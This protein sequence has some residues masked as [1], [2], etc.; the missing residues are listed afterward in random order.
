MNTYDFD[1][2]INRH[3][4]NSLKWDMYSDDVLPLW[5]ADM[6]FP[7]PPAV[8]AAMQTRLSHPVFGYANH[9]TEVLD[10]ICSWLQ[11][12]HGWQIAAEQILLMPGVVTGVNW[13]AK[14]FG[15]ANRAMLIQTPVYPPFFQA[16]KNAGL[17]LVEAPLVQTNSHY[18]I[19][20]ELFEQRILASNANIFILCNPHNPV[21]RVFTRGE[22]ERLGEI[23]LR[24]QV[25]ICSDEIHCDLTYSGY[26]HLPIASLSNELA[27]NTITLMAASKT[28]NIPGLH[29]SFAV[30]SNAELR[31]KMEN[32]RAGIIGHPETFANAAA[33][34]AFS[35]CDDWLEHLL[36][37]LEGNRDH[38]LSFLK[39]NMPAIQCPS[40]QATY[41]A[42]LDCRALD[43]QPDAYTFF[44]EKARVALNDGKSFG[45]NGAGFVRLNFGCPRATLSA[46]LERM[47]L[48]LEQ[49]R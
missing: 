31:K 7:A 11:R 45:G 48:A 33:R 35:Q 24:H 37:Y 29:F 34:A 16:A 21:G 47:Q 49:S 28:F 43:L 9:D 23:C 17:N 26:R 20:F 15:E 1:T 6:D 40:P 22:L 38:L 44:L 41:L 36:V 5:V 2:I 39:R 10:I 25:L 12:R 14:T 27:D 4:T 8:L 46:A 19:D 18:E 3:E 30:I 42:W 32:S 13:A